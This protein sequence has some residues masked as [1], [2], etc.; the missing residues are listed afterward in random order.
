MEVS[1]SKSEVA[2]AMPARWSN[3]HVNKRHQSLA[4]DL[5]FLCTLGIADTNLGMEESREADRVMKLSNLGVSFTP[6]N[7]KCQ[8]LIGVM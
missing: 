3:H 6:F 7:L 4:R 2:R 8:R 1:L 5:R